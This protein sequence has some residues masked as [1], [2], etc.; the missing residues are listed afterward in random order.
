[1]SSTLQEVL[2]RRNSRRRWAFGH[3]CSSTHGLDRGLRRTVGKP[4]CHIESG[5]DDFP[6][7]APIR[8][9]STS[10]CHRWRSLCNYGWPDDLGDVGITPL[11][12][13]RLKSRQ[14]QAFISSR[15]EL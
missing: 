2:Y 14:Q 13:C 12:A 15:A 1:M 9:V 7:A 3:V 5:N 10:P 11:F 8:A 6:S 4:W